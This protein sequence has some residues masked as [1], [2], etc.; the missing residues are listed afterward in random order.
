[1]RLRY[2]DYLYHRIAR[3]PRDLLSRIRRILLAR[4]EN[5]LPQMF[6]DLKE[7]FVVLG[8]KGRDLQARLFDQCKHLLTVQQQQELRLFLS[9]DYSSQPVSTRL[10]V[11]AEQATPHKD[12]SGGAEGDDILQEVMAYLEQGQIEHAQAR[13]EQALLEHSDNRALN[14][15]LLD[16][17]RRS[18]DYQNLIRM[19]GKLEPLNEQ[20]GC[21]WDTVSTQMAPA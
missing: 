12:V 3:D 11:I 5:Q 13:L 6:D 21:L 9:G 7:L 17:Y 16:I 10:L 1:M 20:I 15:M 4:A 18:G 8:N 14:E 19:R 2:L